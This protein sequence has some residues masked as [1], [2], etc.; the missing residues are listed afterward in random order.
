[1]YLTAHSS[2]Q[3]LLMV[4]FFSEGQEHENGWGRVYRAASAL[5]AQ[6][7]HSAHHTVWPLLHSPCAW[8]NPIFWVWTQR[9]QLSR[10]ESC[11]SVWAP[12]YMQT[13]KC[14]KLS[15]LLHFPC[16]LSKHRS[17]DLAWPAEY[18]IILFSLM[19]YSVSPHESQASSPFLNT[20]FCVRCRTLMERWTLVKHAQ[21]LYALLEKLSYN[22]HVN[23]NCMP[24]TVS[25]A[26]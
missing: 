14:S 13:S 23:K 6:S 8:P 22:S 12:S 16:S 26:N 11:M 20:F 3:K 24:E 9:T 4:C 18:F 10:A 15:S 19:K 1:M 21:L 5:P 2:F 25:R 17:L 7:A